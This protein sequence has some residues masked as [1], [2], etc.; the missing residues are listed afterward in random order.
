MEAR[1]WVVPV[2][3]RMSELAARIGLHTELGKALH[4]A[5]GLLASAVPPDTVPAG[6]ELAQMQ[7]M[8]QALRQNAANTAAMRQTGGPQPGGMPGAPGGMPG[9]HPA[10]PRPPSIPGMG[11]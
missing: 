6:A 4:K 11:A 2:A 3:N 9:G 1:V 7:K 10:M 8:Q 5:A